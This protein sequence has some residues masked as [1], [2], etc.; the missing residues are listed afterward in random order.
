MPSTFLYT[1]L[2]RDLFA[3]AKFLLFIFTDVAILSV[4]RVSGGFMSLSGA[5]TG[6]L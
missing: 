3:I 6:N 1:Q 5:N 2:L 4:D